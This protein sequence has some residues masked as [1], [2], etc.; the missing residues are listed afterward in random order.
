MHAKKKM[1]LY[2]LMLIQFKKRSEKLGFKIETKFDEEEYTFSI[3]NVHIE[4][5]MTIYSKVFGYRKESEKDALIARAYEEYF[6]DMF[7]YGIQL[8]YESYLVTIK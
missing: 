1:A 4:S 5:G 7:E 2:S 3:S 8:N 6:A